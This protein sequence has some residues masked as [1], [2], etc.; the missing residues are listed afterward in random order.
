MSETTAHKAFRLCGQSLWYDNISRS[1]I[2]S[3]ELAKLRDAGVRGV[4]SNP[5]IFQKA[6]TSDQEYETQLRQLVYGGA[7]VFD[8]HLLALGQ[9][10]GE[11]RDLLQVIV[12]AL[13]A[14]LPLE[15]VARRACPPPALLA[16]P[17]RAAGAR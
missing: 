4:T 5:S 16:E 12:Q 1:L 3:G 13:A 6:I 8:D 15:T 2:R 11:G 7:G 10:R 14:Q 9:D 17:A